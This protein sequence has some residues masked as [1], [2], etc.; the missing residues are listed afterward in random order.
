MRYPEDVRLSAKLWALSL[1][2]QRACRGAIQRQT[3]NTPIL[4]LGKRSNFYVN[5]I[6]S[7]KDDYYQAKDRMANLD[8]ANTPYIHYTLETRDI[9]IESQ[10]TK[11]KRIGSK[12]PQFNL[13]MT[14]RTQVILSI[15]H[16]GDTTIAL[17]DTNNFNGPTRTFAFPEDAKLG[18][19]PDI[20]PNGYP[21]ENELLAAWQKYG[22]TAEVQWRDQMITDFMRPVCNDFINEYIQFEEWDVIKIYSDRNKKGGYDELVDAAQLFENTISEIDADYETGGRMKFYT[23]EYQRRFNECKTTW[24]NFLTKYNFDVIEDEGEVKGEYKQKILLNYIHSLIFTKEFD[25]AETQIARYVAQA[26]IRKVTYYDLLKL[27]RLNEQFRK[28]Y[29]G[30]AERLGWK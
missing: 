19:A 13:I 16:R 10:V 6:G 23:E 5:L 9:I 7:K 15:S 21:T 22:Q 8:A 29:N 17:L 20:K 14:M 12:E 3:R 18:T 4:G 26:D 25:E 1:T 30:N 24:K 2:E 27:R 11:N 28:E